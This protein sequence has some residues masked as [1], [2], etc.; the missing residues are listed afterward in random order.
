M[1][2]AQSEQNEDTFRILSEIDLHHRNNVLE[3][4]NYKLRCR[5]DSHTILPYP[6]MHPPTHP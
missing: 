6:S 3:T 2:L 5:A 4:V 1:Q